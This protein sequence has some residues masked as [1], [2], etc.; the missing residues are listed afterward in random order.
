MQRM[1]NSG[2]ETEVVSG[3]RVES[4]VKWRVDWKVEQN[5]GKVGRRR[6]W[7]VTGKESGSQREADSG[8]E[9][10]RLT[11]SVLI[12]GMYL[13]SSSTVFQCYSL[14]SCRWPWLVPQVSG[15]RHAELMH[16]HHARGTSLPA[17]HADLNW[18]DGDLQPSGA[19][20]RQF[21]F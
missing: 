9:L 13:P 2:E 16:G 21:R 4:T 3:V 1:N 5:M 14:A 10:A 18:S 19:P 15:F 6:G 20:F 11:R 17:P 7:T 12:A 8:V